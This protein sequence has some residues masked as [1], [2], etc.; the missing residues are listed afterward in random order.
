[1]KSNNTQSKLQSVET[2]FFLEAF[3]LSNIPTNHISH[4]I[5]V[6]QQDNKHI[7]MHFQNTQKLPHSF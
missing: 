5:K 4:K 7:F 2:H 1:M 6:G 3:F